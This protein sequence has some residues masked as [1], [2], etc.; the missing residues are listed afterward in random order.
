MA[1]SKGLS[2]A[3]V[4]ALLGLAA[5]IVFAPRPSRTDATEANTVEVEARPGTA[6][7]EKVTDPDRWPLL[8]EPRAP[9]TSPYRDAA[10]Q[11]RFADDEDDDAQVL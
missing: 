8:K 2:G 1:R 10:D 5:I 4:V 3:I 6:V 11:N 7:P 9:S